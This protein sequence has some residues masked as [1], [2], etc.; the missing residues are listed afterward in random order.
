MVLEQNQTVTTDGSGI[1]E[2]VYTGSADIG[3]MVY[4]VV[5]R[6]NVTPTESFIWTDTVQQQ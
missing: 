1:L 4:V 6:P 2:V 3:A 5:I